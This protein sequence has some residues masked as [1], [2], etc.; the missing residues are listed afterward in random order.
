MA[1]QPWRTHH[2]YIFSVHQAAWSEVQ[3][4]QKEDFISRPRNEA[5]K[6]YT[7]PE[8]E[9]MDKMMFLRKHGFSRGEMNVC[10]R[11]SGRK[12]NLS[13]S[14][15]TVGCLKDGNGICAFPVS[16]EGHPVIR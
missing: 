15:N 10:A 6:Q 4:K 5:N 7:N 8:P 2:R 1:K 3:S 11:G 12:P 13:R 16:E 14:Q 9:S